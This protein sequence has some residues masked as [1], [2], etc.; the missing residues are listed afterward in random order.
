MDNK[1]VQ[2]VDVQ[3]AYA[4]ESAGDSWVLCGISLT[5]HQGEFVAIHGRSGTGKSTLLH[6]VGG[7]LAPRRGRVL[8][9]GQDL[10]QLGDRALS[11]FRNR[12]LGF[13]F[14]NYYLAPSLTAL[15]NVMVPA[16]LSG[17]PVHRARHRAMDALDQVGLAAKAKAR[18]GDLSGGQ[19][20]RVAIARALVNHPALLLADEP[21]GNL[22]EQTGGEI[23]DLL[24]SYQRA[25]GLTILMA[26]HDP[27]VELHATSQ[28]Y[29]IGGKL[30]AGTGAV[31]SAAN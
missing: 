8:I 4:G 10:F 24:A 29:L 17:E 9:G 12:T 16:L 15:E 13:V 2:V 20:Q 22:D 1:L 28:L 30:Q 3:H 6:I 18:P 26:T 19:M 21:T 23:M 5:V 7:I 11:H 25:R 31:E 14:Q 27:S